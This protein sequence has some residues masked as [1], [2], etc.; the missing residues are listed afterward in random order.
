MLGRYRENT[1]RQDNCIWTEERNEYAAI[2]TKRT[3]QRVE[4]RKIDKRFWPKCWRMQTTWSSGG[5][6]DGGE[7]CTG[8]TMAPTTMQTLGAARCLSLLTIVSETLT[9]CRTGTEGGGWSEE[10]AAAEREI[11]REPP[12]S[13]GRFNDIQSVKSSGRL[14]RQ[15]P[16][17]AHDPP[18]P[19]PLPSV[20]VGH[21][22][23]AFER[24]QSA[25]LLTY[26]HFDTATGPIMFKL[27]LPLVL[28]LKISGT[29]T[30]SRAQT[31]LSF[32][33]SVCTK[34]GCSLFSSFACI[35]FES[36][37]ESQS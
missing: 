27:L 21:P 37:T 13:D 10:G 11:Y 34:C 9:E 24:C 15:I 12:R 5:W 1:D 31:R 23:T 3:I 33:L 7:M 2:G 26:W 4:K 20:L 14:A 30:T 25:F 8:R 35:V 19:R 22:C 28:Q 6:A 16:L 17:E 32:A 29:M 18:L 36:K